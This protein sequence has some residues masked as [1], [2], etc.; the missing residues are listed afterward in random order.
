MV[1]SFSIHNGIVNLYSLIFGLLDDPT[2]TLNMISNE[3]LSDFGLR[4]LSK[5]DQ[6]YRFESDYYRGN[7]FVW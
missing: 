1:N 6:F 2:N 4:S 7:I 3:L 5:Y